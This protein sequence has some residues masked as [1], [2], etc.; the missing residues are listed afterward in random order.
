M[1]SLRQ[2]LT[3]IQQQLAVL[4]RSQQLAIVLC[5]VIVGGSLLWLTQWSTRPTLEPLLDQPMTPEEINTTTEALQAMRAPFEERG[6]RLYV[7]PED[8]RKLQRQLASQGA[9]PRDTSLGFKNLLEQ[10][11]PFQPESIN[12]RNFMIAL[13]N[14]LAAVIAEGPEVASADVFVNEVQQRRPGRGQN[15]VPTASV[16]VRTKPGRQLDQVSVQAIANLVSGAV[17]GME[18]H[19]VSI[20]VDGRPRSLPD[21]EDAMS[22]GLLEQTE[23]NEHHFEEKIRDLLSYIPGVKVAVAV[24]LETT[25]KRIER[26]E[27]GDP[28]P[29]LTKTVTE[30]SNTGTPAGETGVNPNTGTALTGGGAGQSTTK[31]DTVEEFFPGEVLSVETQEQVP[32][33]VRGVKASVHIP[34]SYFASVYR[35]QNPQANEPT[36]ADLKVLVEIEQQRVRAVVRNAIGATDDAAVQVDWFPDL[37]PGSPGEFAASPLLAGA[38]TAEKE[39]AVAGLTRYAPQAGLVGLA[40]VSL[41]MMLMLVRKSG[42]VAGPGGSFDAVRAAEA[43]EEADLAAPLHQ[44]EPTEGFLVGQEIDESTLRVQNLSD[45]VSRM[46][47][48]DPETAAELIRRWI[49]TE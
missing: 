20:T 41:V 28:Q 46:V 27:H 21:P 47:D 7:R 31:E 26:R 15:M 45:Q 16:A 10:D 36:D 25:R 11:S 44:V 30:E 22:Y 1:G 35:A 6:D 49:E 2:L 24:E 4:T 32:L 8:R 13:Q 23:K 34:R 12:R 48:E 18:P 14:E 43:E 42:R 17:A 40:L 33:T 3:R 9:L 5:A 38:G 19:R 29:K 39:G 37:A